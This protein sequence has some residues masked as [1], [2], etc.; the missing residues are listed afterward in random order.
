MLNLST[1]RTPGVYIDEVPKFPPSIAA[2]ETAIPAFIGYTEKAQKISNN[3]LKNIPTRIESIAEFERFFGGKAEANI[4]VDLNADNSVKTVSSA[5]EF[6]LYESLQM[7]YANG[8]GRCYIVSIGT[9][10]QADGSKTSISLND[11]KAGLTEL[12]RYDEPTII[13][14]PDATLLTSKG[15][16]DFQKEALIQC[17][18]LMDRVLICDLYKADKDNHLDKVNEFRDKIGINNLKYGGAYTPWI[19]STIPQNIKYREITL[20]SGGSTTTFNTLTNDSALTQLIF[21][22]D[23]S[24]KA[25]DFWNFSKNS[26]LKNTLLK[27]GPTEFVSLEERFKA[28]F[29]AFKTS[30]NT[31]TTADPLST[32]G[33]EIRKITSLMVEIFAYIYEFK[34]TL[35]VISATPGTGQTKDFSLA[36]VIDDITKNNESL[37]NKIYELFEHA[38]TLE[39]LAPSFTLISNYSGADI[40][41]NT[42]KTGKVVELFG[43][44]KAGNKV[45]APNIIDTKVVATYNGVANHKE[46]ID[47]TKVFLENVY[48]DFIGTVS[49]TL[50]SAQEFEKRFDES[51]TERFAYLKNTKARIAEDISVLPPSAVIAG[52]YAKTDRERG[53]WKAPANV[54]LNAVSEPYV[55]LTA[56]NQEELN[57]DVNAGKSINAI[58]TFTGKGVLVWGARTLAGNDNEWRYVSVR[59]FFNMVEESCK[60]ATEQFVFEPNDANTWV[61]VQAMI[62]NFLTTLWRQGALQGA[63]PEHAFYVAVGLGKTM[64]SLDILEGRMIVEIGMAVVRPAEFI[65]LRFSHKMPES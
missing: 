6:F 54:S 14:A 1:L 52:V 63:I 65:V 15:L 7:F 8:G 10:K 18:N 60:K 28:H 39:A 32:V 3:D 41:D 34:S 11:F 50:S 31:M 9:Y 44:T 42:K 62:E 47:K 19:K 35:P 4:E 36:S 30:W 17:A 33:S 57:V 29:S 56:K 45:D 5:N 26:T 13:L 16:Y 25:V 12:E 20:K 43:L 49:R 55:M 61:K 38:N 59:R 24:I 48:S 53:V 22:L 40:N 64:T 27:D 37:K 58:R 23:S 2:V 51:L 46:R 21:D